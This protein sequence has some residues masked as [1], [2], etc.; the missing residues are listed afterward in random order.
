[1]WKTDQLRTEAL[2]GGGHLTFSCFCYMF[3]FGF[4]FCCRLFVLL[5]FEFCDTGSHVAQA[6]LELLV[7]LPLPPGC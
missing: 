1:M 2:R 3:G 5:C 4:W 6:G 7:L